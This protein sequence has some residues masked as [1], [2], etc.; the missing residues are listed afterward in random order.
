MT[1]VVFVLLYMSLASENET[2]LQI[3]AYSMFAGALA[4]VLLVMITN[5]CKKNDKTIPYSDMVMKALEEYF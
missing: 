3:I 1:V 2:L 4:I 5:F